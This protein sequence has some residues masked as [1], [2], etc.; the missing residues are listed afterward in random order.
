MTIAY[1]DNDT[2]DPR[3]RPDHAAQ[4]RSKEEIERE[5]MNWNKPHDEGHWWAMNEIVRLREENAQLRMCGRC[6]KLVPFLLKADVKNHSQ[7]DAMGRPVW[8]ASR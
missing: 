6:M 3:H 7:L 5:F 4:A 8:E 1:R 2:L